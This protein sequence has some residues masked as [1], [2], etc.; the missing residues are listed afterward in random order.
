MNGYLK[1]EEL[2]FL[3]RLKNE[4]LDLLVEILIKDKN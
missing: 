2:S 4:D 1:N 3:N